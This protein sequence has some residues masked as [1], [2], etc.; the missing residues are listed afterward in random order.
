VKFCKEGVGGETAHQSG[1]VV[2]IFN[3][4]IMEPGEEDFKFKA[5]LGYI[6][7]AYFTM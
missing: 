7:T 4:N 5:S 1:M 3:P 6:V 2:H